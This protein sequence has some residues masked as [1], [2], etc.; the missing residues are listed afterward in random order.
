MLDLDRQDELRG[1][2]ELLYFAYRGFT[3]RPDRILER[4]GLGRVHHRILHFIGSRPDI[5]VRGLLDLLA[6]SKQAL[7]APL[8]QLVEMHLVTAL[9]AAGD[10]RVKN[11]RL[12]PEGERLEAELTGVQARHLQTAFDRAGPAAEQGWRTVMTELAELAKG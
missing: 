5:S 10:R 7:N 2:I 3:D 12:T 9:P 6:V 8:R 1:A 11:L 4:R